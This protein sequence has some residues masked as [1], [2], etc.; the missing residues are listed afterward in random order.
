MLEHMRG[1]RFALVLLVG[2]LACR[3]Y[4]AGSGK[5]PGGNGTQDD[6][7]G[8]LGA[9]SNRFEIGHEGSDVEEVTGIAQANMYGAYGGD[10]YGYGGGM[11][12][13]GLYGGDPY[14]GYGYGYQYGYGYGYG[15][16]PYPYNPPAVHQIKYEVQANLTASLEGTITWAGPPVAKLTTACGL[17]DNPSIRVTDKAVGGALVYIENVKIGRQT[18]IY[19]RQASVGGSIGKHGCALLPATQIV[20]PVPTGLTVHGD[21]TKAKIKITTADSKSKTIEM[22][23]AGFAQSQI[24]SGV[25]KVESD[26]GKLTPA[27]VVGLDTPY[28]AITDDSGH[29]RIDELSPG[30]YEVTIWQAP[31]ATAGANGTVNAGSPIVTKRQVVVD[32]KK[33]AQLDVAIKP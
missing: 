2:G 27:W 8:L 25:T 13:G 5:L 28:Y 19:G 16:Q 7:H 23:E 3:T 15:Y 12:G 32:A 17:I 6:G 9:A 1:G 29:F 4:S 22:Q 30:T 20:T 10:V 18:Q 24:D 11:Y 31:V 33:A 21:A 26:D 14:G